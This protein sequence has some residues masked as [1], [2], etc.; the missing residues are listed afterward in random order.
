MKNFPLIP[1]FIIKETEDFSSQSFQSKNISFPEWE[2]FRLP[3]ELGLRYMYHQG[4]MRAMG[5]HMG[6]TIH[7]ISFLLYC[8]SIPWIV[9][10][11]SI[12]ETV[13]NTYMYQSLHIELD[14]LPPSGTT[15]PHLIS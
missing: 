12:R 1:L 2:G 13:Q 4:R 8:I 15:I 5:L 9:I 7:S 11:Y 14:L 3:L 10:L 6:H